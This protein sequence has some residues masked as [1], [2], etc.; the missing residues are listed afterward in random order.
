MKAVLVCVDYADFLALTLPRNIHH[1]E[2][3]TVVTTST[4]TATLEVCKSLGVVSHTTDKFYLGGAH[5]NKFAALEEGLDVCG[6]D[7]W[8]CVMDA[9][10]VWPKILS[11]D[12]EPKIGNL[13]TPRRRMLRT[14]YF[15][16]PAEEEWNTIPL[17][18]NEQWIGYTQIFHGS[19]NHLGKPPWYGTNWR[20]A[21]GADSFFQ[22]KWN[23]PDKVRPS[24]E[25]LHLGDEGRNWCGRITPYADGTCPS[26]SPARLAALRDYRQGRRSS[27]IPPS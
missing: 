21:G 26:E 6:R 2:S 9:D 1:F 13:Y 10:I 12:F 11:S 19:D 18:G 5:F 8:L 22:S 17:F 27:R 23:S 3:V 16:I 15:Q 25:V 24:W 7:G 4:D 14:N 20:H